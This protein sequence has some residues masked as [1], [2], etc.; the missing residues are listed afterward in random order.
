M[1]IQIVLHRYTLPDSLADYD[2]VYYLDGIVG[3]RCV[4]STAGDLLIWDRALDSNTAVAKVN[5]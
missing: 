2:E 5:R 3:D 1:S 4:N